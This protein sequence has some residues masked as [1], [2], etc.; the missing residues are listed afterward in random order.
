MYDF[1]RALSINPRN[2]KNLKRLAQV[3]T[4]LGNLGEAE[5]NLNKCITIE[6]K[7]YQHINELKN[8]KGIIQLNNDLETAYTKKDFEK[9]EELSKKLLESCPESSHAKLVHIESLLKNLKINQALSFLNSKLNEEEK[10][11]DEFDYLI[12][13]A[14]Y[15]DGK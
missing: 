13:L 10:N 4:I 2:T 7:E 14:F 8:L 12:V 6:P 11:K 3:L 1:N 9:A 5:M 15:Y